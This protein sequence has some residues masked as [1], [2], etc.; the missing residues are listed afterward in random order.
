[1]LFGGAIAAGFTAPAVS[2]VLRTSDDRGRI[3]TA[4]A[5][6]VCASFPIL[7]SFQVIAEQVLSVQGLGQYLYFAVLAQEL[8][9]EVVKALIAVLLLAS[10]LVWAFHPTIA[11]TL[12]ET[13][14][15]A[16]PCVSRALL[17]PGLV[18]VAVFLLAALIGPLVS[19]NPRELSPTGRYEPPSWSHLLGT[20]ALG[21]DLLAQVVAACRSSLTFT[22][23]PILLGLLPGLTIGT[24]LRDWRA[25]VGDVMEEIATVWQALPVLPITLLFMSANPFAFRYEVAAVTI[26][27]FAI[28]L[29][30]SANT[31]NLDLKRV[32]DRWR[33]GKVLG[34]GASIVAVSAILL[35]ET[36]AFM[37]LGFIPG[38]SAFGA[39]ISDGAS[40][41]VTY[42]RLWLIPSLALT[43]ILFGFMLVRRSLDDEVPPHM[44][45]R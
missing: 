19:T 39:L 23:A 27:A 34:A 21:Q 5:V 3:W 14:N 35:D 42:V 11:P 26:G 20:N 45:E 41:G 30:L 8:E 12:S 18:L 13:T 40:D 16:T 28:G 4:V 6:S 25:R 37:G 43:A 44:Y 10:L 2:R 22:L 38:D 36:L 24:A 33:Y 1:M 15:A 32:E 17:I 31:T 29:L 9:L 7:L